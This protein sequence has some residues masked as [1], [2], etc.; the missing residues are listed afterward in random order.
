[1]LSSALDLIFPPYCVSCQKSGQ[2]LCS[3]CYNR[4]EFYSQSLPLIT[5]PENL[6][7]ILV[8]GRHQAPLNRLIIACKYQQ[9][10]QIGVFLARLVYRHLTLPPVDLITYVPTSSKRLRQRGFNQAQVIAQKLSQLVNKPCFKLINKEQA[11]H[12]Q[13]R[14]NR[15]RRMQNLKLCFSPHENLIKLKKVQQITVLLVDDVITTGATLN[16]CAKIL[17]AAGIKEI[18]GLAISHQG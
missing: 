18:K 12:H 10:R 3:K 15:E 9:V 7:Q 16:Q 4:L 11:S 6:N 2:F 5:K 14:L 13:A 1:M 17:R 8:L